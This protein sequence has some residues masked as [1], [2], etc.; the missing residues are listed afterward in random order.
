ML[1][2]DS[3]AKK[4]GGVSGD[5]ADWLLLTITGR[6]IADVVTGVVEFYLADFRFADNSQDY[7]V[8]TWQSVDLTSL[9]SVKS[10]EFSLSS[11]D[12]GEF[13]MNTP[14]YFVVD[15]VVPEPITIALLGL[16]SLFVRRFRS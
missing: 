3:F 6:D 13:G 10:I 14:G 15:S 8:N 1:N 16:G 2:G 5:D 7:I 11:T 12:V 4:F 9:G